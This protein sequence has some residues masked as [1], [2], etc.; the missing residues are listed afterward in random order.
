[1]RKQNYMETSNELTQITPSQEIINSPLCSDVED[2]PL[3]NV[4]GDTA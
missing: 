4:L 2:T 3:P 1:M